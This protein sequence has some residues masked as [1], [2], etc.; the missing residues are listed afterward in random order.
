M[1][2][3]YKLHLCHMTGSVARKIISVYSCDFSAVITNIAKQ[4]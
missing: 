4:S 1:E 3:G 2:A